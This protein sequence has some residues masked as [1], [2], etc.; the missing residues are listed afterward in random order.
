MLFERIAPP[1]KLERF[2][3]CYWVVESTN[4]TPEIQK[5]IPDGFPEIIFHYGDSYK[6]NIK[7]KWEL[8]SKSLIAG[9]IKKH[10]FLQ[11]TGRSGVF[12]IKFRPAGLM[13]LFSTPMYEL[14]DKALPLSEI[15]NFFFL[16]LEREIFNCKGYKEM[17]VV[18]NQFLQ[19]QAK[20]QEQYNDTIDKA[21]DLIFK[22]NG[23][24]AVNELAK[25]LF[26]TE[27]QLQRLFRKYIGLSPK[28]YARI[29]RFN[30]IFQL[31]QKK[32]TSW[33]DVTY[34]SGYFDQSHFIRDFKAFTGEDP[35]QY[36]F[37]GENMANFFLKRK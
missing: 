10:F 23:T 4:T 24:L 34:H 1:K 16:K 19:E 36:F 13:H 12:G 18:V 30:Y 32:N 11:N 29:I 26:S 14:T 28:F 9:Q 3:E 27:R 5:I 25:N 15:K 33:L 35:S 21:V 8:Q 2:I 7:N 6:I 31:I 37:E 20:Q 22:S 17:I